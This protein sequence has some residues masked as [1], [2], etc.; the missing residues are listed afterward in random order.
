MLMNADGNWSSVLVPY[1][2]C[3]WPCSPCSVATASTLQFGRSW[4]W[5]LSG[6]Q[7][8]SLS[9]DH[10]K[11]INSPFT[12]ILCI[13]KLTTSTM[14]ERNMI[15]LHYF[16]SFLI[17]CR[18]CWLANASRVLKVVYNMIR[19]GLYFPHIFQVSNLESKIHLLANVFVNVYQA[20]PNW[21]N[22]N[23]VQNVITWY[24]SGV[25]MP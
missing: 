13:E 3:K 25:K 24:A 21:N 15:H 19:P 11:L 4:V 23:V 2:L 8:L 6:I 17:T 9:H 16:K 20:C 5:F 18:S 7:I 22:F 10:D 1:E 14:Q 12:L